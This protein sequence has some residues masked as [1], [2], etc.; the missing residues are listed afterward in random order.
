MPDKEEGDR[1]ETEPLPVDG[2]PPAAGT[3]WARRLLC[4]PDLKVAAYFASWLVSLLGFCYL[5][6]VL[7]PGRPN[8]DIPLSGSSFVSFF[9][10]FDGGWFVD[11]AKY[12]YTGFSQV[13]GWDCAYIS[14]A[15]FPLYPA[16]I[17]LAS[18]PLL[19]HYYGAALLVSWSSLLGCLVYLRRLALIY[20]REGDDGDAGF[21]ACLCLLLFP[22]AFFLAAG[23]SESLF[24]LCAAGAL[25]HARRSS[26]VL[27]GAWGFLACLARP[28]GLAVAAAVMLEAA[29]QA[30]W[31]PR[32]LKPR[33][34]AVLLAPLGLASYMAYLWWRFS[35][36]LIF[37]EAEKAGEGWNR[38]FNL[39]GPYRLVKKLFNSGGV[40]NPEFA[41]YLYLLA[42]M[43]SMAVLVVL[44]FRRYG[45][46]L[47]AFSLLCLLPPLLTSPPDNPMMSLN[48][49]VIVIL[50]AF[51]L[52]GEWCRNR[53]F[54]RLYSVA[55]TLGL[56]LFSALFVYGMWAG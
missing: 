49:L 33:M 27:S 8:N 41:K 12:G 26:W 38:E 43:V 39:L 44:V 19:G 56:A 32:G 50:P 4:S 54:E 42:F 31:R 7:N 45:Y 16:A 35:D 2:A 52:L 13:R 14:T 36:P 20:R 6:L 22:T 29:R 46:P 53:D 5:V 55:G 37:T 10:Y 3:G 9:F 30:G 24:L 17:R 1:V 18:W 51:L 47:G 40:F 15:F 34:A 11:I 48:R 21:R 25:Y 23:Y 28:V